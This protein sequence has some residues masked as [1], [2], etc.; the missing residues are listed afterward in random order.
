MPRH[1][2]SGPISAV[3]ADG[4]TTPE[5]FNFT[6]DVIE[7]FAEVPHTRAALSHVDPN[8]V[9][10][11]LLFSELAA[12]AAR[13][14]GLLRTNGVEAGDRVIV[15]IGTRP[16]WHEVLL[17]VLKLGGI[18]VPCPTA[19]PAEELAFRARDSAAC[20]VVADEAVRPALAG[21]EN[22]PPVLYVD[23]ASELLGG[24]SAVAQTHD[25]HAD[26][27]AF[28]LY[29]SGTTSRPKGVVQTHGYCFATAMQAEHWLEVEPRDRVWCAHAMGSTES[30]CNGLLGPWSRGAEVVVDEGDFVPEARVELIER[31]GVTT[32]CQTPSEYRLMAELGDLRKPLGS[33]RAAVS[34]GEVLDRDVIEAFHEASGLT[35]RDGYG[36]TETTLLIGNLPEATRAGSIGVATPGHIVALIDHHGR[37]VPLGEE[38]DIAV[39][40]DPPGLFVGYWNDLDATLAKFRGD[41]YVTGD[42]ATR[43][44]DGYFWLAGRAED[45]IVTATDRILPTALERLLLANAAV[46]EAAVVAKPD[47]AGHSNAVKA[48]VVLHP[49]RKPTETLQRR[50]L[51]QS[52]R[53][54]PPGEV[55]SE[56]EFVDELPKTSNGKI[57]RVELRTREF[58]RAGLPVPD[59]SMQQSVDPAETEALELGETALIVA[60]LELTGREGKEGRSE[61]NERAE[62]RRRERDER[63]RRRQRQAGA[64]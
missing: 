54:L 23:D 15:S 45:V 46:A 5:R 35:V 2:V 39:F 57:R 19:L 25:T 32:L 51:A 13:W 43:D 38:G 42:R 11:R 55:P 1:V 52:Q 44:E 21:V 4:W 12:R 26:D 17:A 3:D 9:I 27:A 16:E 63:R 47:P 49:R 28:I 30:I 48:F 31:L 22:A 50:L 8:G 6:R 10:D 24:E 20:L 29:T 36:Q 7:R 58:E 41:W 34:S 64:D 56:I 33:L 14:A 62:D 53:K 37:E 40:G 61:E 60:A 59:A 18:A